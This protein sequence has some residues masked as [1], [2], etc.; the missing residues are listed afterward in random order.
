MSPIFKRFKI[1]LHR[2]FDLSTEMIAFKYIN[3]THKSTD[4]K[5]DVSTSLQR[6]FFLVSRT[7]IFA[8]AFVFSLNAPKKWTLCHFWVEDDAFVLALIDKSAFFL[9]PFFGVLCFDKLCI[10][11]VPLKLQRF[12]I[13]VSLN[14]NL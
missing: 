7:F 5:L 11:F 13:N 8:L 2:V 9:L 12:R 14:M 3:N 4:E 10:Q 1:N 6:F